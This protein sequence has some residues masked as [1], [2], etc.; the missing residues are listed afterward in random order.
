M[1]QY[2]HKYAHCMIHL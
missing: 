2:K 1:A